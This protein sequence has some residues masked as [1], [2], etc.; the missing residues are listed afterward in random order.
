MQ[1]LH[2]SIVPQFKAGDPP[3]SGYN[4]WHEWA[5]VQYKSGLRQKRCET[6]KRYFF[7][8]EMQDGVCAECAKK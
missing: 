6:C 8:Q 2:I 5:A 1:K 7:A 4:Q 3:P